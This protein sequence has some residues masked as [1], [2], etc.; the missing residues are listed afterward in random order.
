MEEEDQEGG[1]QRG[2]EVAQVRK[3]GGRHGPDDQVTEQ[4][5]AQRGDLGEYGDAEHVEVLAD[6]Q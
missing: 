2:D 5:A 4:P 6:G 3:G 1:E